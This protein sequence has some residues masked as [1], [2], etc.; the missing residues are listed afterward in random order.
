[1]VFTVNDITFQAGTELKISGK[2]KSDCEGFSINVG[3]D[4][5]SVA[6]HFNPRFT[7]CGDSR[8]I[9]CNSNNHGGWGDEHREPCFPFQ[10]GE[11]FKVTI[12]F[13]NETFYIKLPDGNMMSFPN[14]FGDDTFNHVHVLG[15][16]K[17]NS[18]KV[19]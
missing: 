3:H 5:D 9:V 8:V 6:L 2:V 1:M 13:N 12:T 19:K 17:V 11:E 18:I 15:D 10:Q 16:V 14:R 4:C 7:Q